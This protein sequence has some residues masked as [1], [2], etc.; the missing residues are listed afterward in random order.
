VRQPRGA[1]FI[2][3]GWKIIRCPPYGHSEYSKRDKLLPVLEMV[4]VTQPGPTA[5]TNQVMSN[6]I[7]EIIDKG[8]RVKYSCFSCN[9][10]DIYDRLK[11][12][13][14]GV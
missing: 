13:E 8:S 3:A 10:M 14:L 4:A 1:V 9:N 2:I 7:Y 5:P 6:Q 11:A 12:A